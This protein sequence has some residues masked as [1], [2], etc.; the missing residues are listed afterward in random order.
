M[1]REK[2]DWTFDQ[3][4]A[5]KKA[6]DDSN[7]SSEDS[8]HNPSGGQRSKDNHPGDENTRI[9]KKSVTWKE[10]IAEEKG[11][12]DAPGAKKASVTFQ[13][14]DADRSKENGTADGRAYVGGVEG[15]YTCDV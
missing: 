6:R 10:P 14:K 3:H 7:K 2:K 11:E 4:L 1:S 15:L 13:N 5:D 8:L 12:T 9:P